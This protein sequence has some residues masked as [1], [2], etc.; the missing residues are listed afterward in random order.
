VLIPRKDTV[1]GRFGRWIE[2][3]ARAGVRFTP[4]QRQWLDLIKDQIAA[5]MAIEMDDFEYAPF[6][7]KGGA[8][9]AFQIFGERLHPLLAELN[10]VL[11]A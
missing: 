8:G 6:A 11:A 1:D 3:Q 10:E 2:E 5:S 9:K 4:E 7:Q